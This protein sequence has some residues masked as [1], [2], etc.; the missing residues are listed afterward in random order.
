MADENDQ[1]NSSESE[2]DTSGQSGTEEIDDADAEA[3]L[4]DAVESD[5]GESATDATDWKAEA[6]K[7]KRLSR[8]N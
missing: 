6:E 7:W 4:A 5:P 2:V 3:L 8:Q 1:Q